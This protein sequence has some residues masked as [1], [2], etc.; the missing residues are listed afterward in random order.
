MQEIKAGV[1]HTSSSQKSDMKK[2]LKLMKR[3][4]AENEDISKKMNTTSHFKKSELS[5]EWKQDELD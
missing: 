5:M 4:Q 3:G 2:K 1:G